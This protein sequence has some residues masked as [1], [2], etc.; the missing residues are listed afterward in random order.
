MTGIV[1]GDDLLVEMMDGSQPPPLKPGFD[2]PD[3]VEEID[4]DIY[5][6][7]PRTH[8]HLFFVA[9]ITR[10]DGKKISPFPHGKPY[11][12]WTGDERNYTWMP[13]VAPSSAGVRYPL[14]RLVRLE[15]GAAIPSPYKP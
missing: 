11:P 13:H 2:Y 9:N 12:A 10:M 7:T 6:F 5:A 1:H 8:R 3:R 4:P 14:S 15:P